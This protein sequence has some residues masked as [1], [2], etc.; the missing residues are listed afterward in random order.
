MRI[1][2]ILSSLTLLGFATYAKELVKFLQKEVE[3]PD[4][5]LYNLKKYNVYEKEWKE[6]GTVDPSK[7]NVSGFFKK[8][9]H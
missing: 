4:G 7:E 3:N 9:K 6:F 8:N 1:T 5:G 2:R